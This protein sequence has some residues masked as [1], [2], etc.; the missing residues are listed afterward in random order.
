[1]HIFTCLLLFSAV[2]FWN[3]SIADPL[4][5]AQ[6][7]EPLKP[8]ISWVLQ[9]NPDQVCPFNYA[10]AEQKRCSWPSRLTLDLKPGKSRFLMTWQVFRDSWVSLPGD[11]EHWP[12]HVSANDKPA[13]VLDRAGA[14]SIKLNAG[15]YRISGEFAWEKLPDNLSIPAETALIDLQINGRSIAAPTIKQGQLW[16]KQNETGT[17]KTDESYNNLDIQVF[18]KIID[19]VPLQVLTRLTLDVSGRQREIRLAKPLLDDFIPLSL[20]S[21]LPARLEADGQLLLQLRPGHWQ[22]DLLSRHVQEINK[23]TLNTPTQDWPSSEIWV[24]AEQPQRRVEVAEVAAIDASQTNL[25]AEWKNLPAYKIE[26]GQSMGLKVIRRGDPEPEPNHLSLNRQ[27]WLDFSGGGYTVSDRINGVMHRDWRLNALPDTR[28]GKVILDGVSQLITRQTG[29]DKSEQQ[30]VEVGNGPINL[31]A[32]SRIEG[33]LSTLSATGWEQTFL[34][35][36]TELNLPPGW[37]LFAATGI[38]NVPDS[39]LSRWSLLDLFMVLIAALATGRLWSKSSG[40]FTLLT[41]VLI[42][43]EP[44]APHYIWLNLLAAEALVRVLPENKFMKFVRSYRLLCRLALCLIAVPFMVAQLR[45]AIYPQ[46]ELDGLNIATPNYAEDA[47]SGNPQQAFLAKPNAVPLAAGG[48]SANLPQLKMRMMSPA[49]SSLSVPELQNNANQFVRIDPKA[50]V[51][52]GP[53]LP[54]WQWRKITLAWNGSVDSEQKF[55]LWLLSPA[56]NMLLNILRVGL[57]AGLA[58]LM[59]GV[60]GQLLA[61]LKPA[62]PALLWLLALPLLTLPTKVSYA[63]FPSQEILDT[64]KSKLLAP[65]DCQPACAAIEA[66]QITLNDRELIITLTMH[67]QQAVAAPL[68]GIIEQWFPNQ[69]SLDGDSANGLYRDQQGLWLNLPVG[70]HQVKLIAAPPALGK[71]SL[72]LPLRPKQV[73]INSSGWEVF[74]L[75]ENG[76]VDNQLQFTRQQTAS[77][78]PS[79]H[80]PAKETTETQLPPLVKI[81]RSLQFGLDWQM[82]TQVQRISAPDTAIVLAVPLLPGEAVTSPG[83]RIKADKVEVNM[84]AGVAVMQ[85]RSS[86]EKSA[87]LNLTAA[88]N[89][90]WLEV[91][92]AD[93]SPIWHL[94]SAGIPMLHSDSGERRRE[95]QPWP[96]E[97]LSLTLSRPEAVAGQTLTIDNS[98]LSMQAGQRGQDVRLT[99]SLRSSLGGQHSIILPEQALLQSVSSNGRNLALHPDGQKLT[100]PINPGFQE[101]SLNWQQSGGLPSLL[102]TPNVDLGAVSVNS[103]LNLVLSEDRWVLWAFGPKLGPA[104]L[105][106]GLL[107]VLGLLAAGLKSLNLTP[108]SFWHWCLLLLG[109]SQVNISAA[110]VVIAWLLLLGWRQ[111][112]KPLSPRLFNLIQITLGCLTLFALGLLFYAVE[113]GLLGSPDMQITGNQSS[114]YNLNW[115]QDRSL[116]SL[117]QAGVISV[118]LL[119]YRL[120]MLAWALWLALSLLN[121]LKWGWRCFS[122]KALWLKPEKTGKTAL[123]TVQPE[124]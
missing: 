109:L 83:V 36:S 40:W 105:F 121:W 30:G 86:L 122:S 49:P 54:Q 113:Q 3:S 15:V 28:L 117:P 102:R 59:F 33:G 21:P 24:F 9:D 20:Q 23:L 1:M 120:F 74:G 115:Y 57:L 12:L 97:Q 35:V 75:Q 77:T 73:S 85:W 61:K 55:E 27:L 56:M 45:I 88:D 99:L 42:W 112:A 110:G 68:P 106:W 84:P 98:S 60:S 18:R 14:P 6:V 52:T 90:Q 10:S 103:T 69:V 107:P 37:R 51:Q 124:L 78:Q 81:S 62:T 123:K 16:L 44:E 100:L 119:V 76:R 13:L 93:V 19:D 25:P 7:P 63:D 8:W 34:S 38:D 92:Q 95:W 11:N 118:P 29:G 4:L 47:V 32:D 70:L 26:Q 116:A 5:P 53:G 39:W 91:W 65:P 50:Q 66:M 48:A 94:E 31:Q 87:K 22:I 71:F 80:G 58:G 43:H 89:S 2:L 17:A 82:T 64:L 108:L 101:I 104:V 114:A 46:L 41:L 67:A 111:Q 72:S 79:E 96:G